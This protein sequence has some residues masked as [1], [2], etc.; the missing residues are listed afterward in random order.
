MWKKHQN[1]KEERL[2]ENNSSRFLTG[3]LLILIASFSFGETHFTYNHQI[4]EAQ[5][6]SQELQ[7]FPARDS[8]NTLLQEDGSNAAIY[9]VLH[10]NYWLEAFISEEDSVY[11]NYK[12]LKAKV[13]A[14]LAELPDSV[15]YKKFAL[16]EVHFFSAMIKAKFG[17]IYSAAREV[18]SAHNL[19]EENHEKFPSFIQNNKSRGIIK[20][21]LSTVPDNYVW[22]IRLLGI[23]GNL[24][25]GLALLHNLSNYKGEDEE[26]KLLAKETGY[27]YSFALF[28]VAKQYGNAWAETL[29]VT[30][31]YQTNG[32][33]CFFRSNMALKMNRNETAIKVLQSRPQGESYYPFYFL[34]YLLGVAKLNRMDVDAINYL[35]KYEQHFKGNNYVKSCLQKQSWYYLLAGNKQEYKRYKKMVLSSGISLNEDDKQAQNFSKKPDP[36]RS[37]LKA[38]LLFD[39]GYYKKA[40]EAMKDLSAKSFTSQNEK[41]EYC[42]RKG[43]IYE[44]LGKQKVSLMFYEACTLI[45]KNSNEYYGAYACLYLGDH[46]LKIDDDENAKLYYERALTYENNNE[47]KDSIEQR[48]KAGLKKI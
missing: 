10:Q 9:F 5:R 35:N 23:E 37:L 8:L 42:Y 22:V 26:L 21:Y 25:E 45:A 32:M 47:Y 38:R 36:N 7:L 41:A 12:E 40:L 18:N 13:L 16:S 24:S 33:S 30:K 17:D 46:Y 39:G 1:Q 28:H 15:P 2:E 20:V 4:L 14:Q 27:V 43:R 29:K 31:D 3:L 11:D 34:D 48:A 44:K 6:M 19:I